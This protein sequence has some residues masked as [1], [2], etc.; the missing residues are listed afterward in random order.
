M[1][2]GWDGQR[3][4][5]ELPG[6]SAKQECSP[7]VSVVIPV[8]NG[9]RTIREQLDALAAQEFSG[10]WEL[11]I[12]DNGST[13]GTADIA[14][15]FH[16]RIPLLRIVQAADGTGINFARNAGVR[17][18]RGERV[19][20]CDADDR[21]HPGWISGHVRALEEFDV[22]GGPLEFAELNPDRVAGLHADKAQT[23]PP[24]AGRFL[25]YAT[26]CNF[27][28][29]REVWDRLGGFDDAWKRGHT[30]TEFCWRAQL[31]GFTL[32]WA[33]T[34]VVSYRRATEVSGELRRLFRSAQA[35]PRLYRTFGERGMPGSFFRSAIRAWAW[36]LYRVPWAVLK[37]VWRLK[38][39][40]VLAWR[41]GRLTGSVRYRTLYL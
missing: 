3:R 10:T 23:G 15:E 8:R 26:G 21:V 13:D 6:V 18:S 38:W 30:E 28:F 2:R 31:E 14:A 32:G 4:S 12:A 9:A 5:T 19:L 29:R 24:V 20:I 41:S 36:L 1:R 39:L 27:G 22:T 17:A 11:V 35:L 25:P 37:P 16:K 40:Q 7:L 33:P 34:A